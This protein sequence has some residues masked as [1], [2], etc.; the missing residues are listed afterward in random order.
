M[1]TLKMIEMKMF[2][3]MELVMAC[4]AKPTLLKEGITVVGYCHLF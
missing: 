2:L 3:N 1:P 4:K